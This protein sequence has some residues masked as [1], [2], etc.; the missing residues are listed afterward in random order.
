ME[1]GD[2]NR[3]HRWCPDDTGGRL[4]AEW[5]CSLRDRDGLRWTCK[6][7]SASICP[8]PEHIRTR[9]RGRLRAEPLG[10]P[11]GH[12]TSTGTR[13]REGKKPVTGELLDAKW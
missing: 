10:T 2:G 12:L 5:D 4:E 9:N 7:Q 11:L 13:S 3:D 6:N 1:S 8:T